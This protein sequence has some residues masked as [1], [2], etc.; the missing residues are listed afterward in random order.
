MQF[1]YAMLAIATLVGCG[2][3]ATSDASGTDAGS[4]TAP[5]T[6]EAPPPP[7]I[8]EPSGADAQCAARA[9]APH[10]TFTADYFFGL[11]GAISASAAFEISNQLSLGFA[12]APTFITG[13]RIDSWFSLALEA[14]AADGGD[15]FATGAVTTVRVW[16]YGEL[17]RKCTESGPSGDKQIANG[18]VL[19]DDAKLE[20]TKRDAATLEGTLTIVTD[21]GTAVLRF[22]SPLTPKLPETQFTVC[23]LQN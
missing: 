22:A 2:R 3:I 6:T 15:A 17:N 10:G 5:V 20:I 19:A 18:T 21:G 7:E 23:C 12:E 4:D 9:A 1:H 14:E 8:T 11:Q 13:A 16:S